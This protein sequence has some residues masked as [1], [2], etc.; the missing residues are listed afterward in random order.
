MNDDRR[1]Q[2]GAADLPFDDTPSSGTLIGAA[3]G[4]VTALAGGLLCGLMVDQFGS[5]GSISLW[6][7]G[8][9]AGLAAFKLMQSRNNSVACILVVACVL[10]FLIAEVSWIHWNIAG[11]ESWMDALAKFPQFLKEFKV[12][13]F[14]ACIFTFFGCQAAY[15]QTAVRSVG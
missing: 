7:L 3:V 6:A 14:I 2:T 1:N 13:A 4:L 10:A 8:F 11:A 9:L 5:I 15:R 12:D